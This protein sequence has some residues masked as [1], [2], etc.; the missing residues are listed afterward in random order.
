MKW[1]LTLLAGAVFGAVAMFYFL[2]KL[3]DGSQITV[4]T[5]AIDGPALAYPDAPPPPA[6]AR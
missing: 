5:R 6:P 4:P 2:Y 3:P 1:L